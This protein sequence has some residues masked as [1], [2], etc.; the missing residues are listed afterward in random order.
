MNKNLKKLISTVAALAITATSTFTAFAANFTDVADTAD[1]K[2]AVDNLV[3]LNIVNGY[4]DGTFGPEKLITRAEA[5]KMIV[6]TM[7]PAMM[8]AAEASKGS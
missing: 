6:G 8:D 4:E 7:G 2:T 5:S 3:A 1:Y